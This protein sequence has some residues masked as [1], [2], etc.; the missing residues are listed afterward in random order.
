VQAERVGV[1]SAH[2]GHREHSDRSIVNTWIGDR[3]R[4]VATPG[5]RRRV[6]ME[7]NET[8][9][10]LHGGDNTRDADGLAHGGAQEVLECVRGDAAEESEELAVM[11]KEWPEPLGH[12]DDELAM[13][14]RVQK[15]VLEPFTPERQALGV[16]G[17]AEVARLAAEGD[18][19]FSAALIA[20]VRNPLI[21]ATLRP[22]AHRIGAQQWTVP[23]MG[24]RTD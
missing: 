21:L 15:F 2:F 18:E 17:R 8:A 16:A 6:R 7:V 19:E 12:G 24:E 22:L 1:V 11:K 9:E 13:G 4:S 5:F 20:A 23:N 10:G 14:N 3:E